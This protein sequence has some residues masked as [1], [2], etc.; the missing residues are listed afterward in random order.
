VFYPK[1]SYLE[2]TVLSSFMEQ[3]NQVQSASHSNNSSP[4]SPT[5]RNRELI[6]ASQIKTWKRALKVEVA[7]LMFLNFC[8]LGALISDWSSSCEGPNLKIWSGVEILVQTLLI[9]PSVLL[10]LNMENF[11]RQVQTRALDPV[12]MCYMFSRVLN[13]F[14]IAWGILGIVWTFQA[15]QCSNSIPAVYTICFIFAILN[16]LIIG[17][18]LLICCLSIPGG[19][20][21]YYLCPRFFGVEPILKASPKLIKKVTKLVIFTEGSMP[22]E[23]ACCAICLCEYQPGEEMRYLNCGHHF[24]SN[25]VTDWLLRNRTCPFCKADIEQKVLPLRQIVVQ[26]LSEEQQPLTSDNGQVAS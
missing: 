21:M 20:A 11:F 23:D 4:S 3:A 8:L 7:S 16:L 5:Q 10:Q 18:P 12:A 19:I 9:F 6:L 22:L 13:M 1:L 24:H 15:K 17:L 26:P 14:W 25:C 2:Y